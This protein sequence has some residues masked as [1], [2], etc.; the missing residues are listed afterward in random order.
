MDITYKWI[1]GISLMFGLALVLN[2]YTFEN[3][4]GFFVFLTLF[5]AFIVYS[6]LLPYWTLILNI[7]ILTFVMYFEVNSKRDD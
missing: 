7:I 2:H 4:K 3:T 5:N 1:L 6:D